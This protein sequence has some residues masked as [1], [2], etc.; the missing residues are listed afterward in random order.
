MAVCGHVG[1]IVLDL[2][3]EIGRKHKTKIKADLY[4]DSAHCLS[5]GRNY[6]QF[7]CITMVTYVNLN[8]TQLYHKGELGTSSSYF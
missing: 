8:K 2:L 3:D 7:N 4:Q 6:P 5:T 1:T